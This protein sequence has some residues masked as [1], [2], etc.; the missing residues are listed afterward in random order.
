MIRVS[1]FILLLAA[2]GLPFGSALPQGYPVKPIRVIVPYGPGD[3]A[4]ILARLIG[5]KLTERF[6]QQLIVDNR[7]GAS[8]QLGLNLAAR[9][10]ADGYTIAVGQ[11]GNM[12]VAPHT[13]KKPL[14]D[15]L[16]DFV[17]VALLATNYAALV[18]HPSA[19]FK[20][21]K[22]L[23]AYAKTQ[24]GKLTFASGGE[25]SFPHLAFELL[26]VQASF[27]YLHVPYKGTA[28]IVADLIVDR[29]IQRWA[30]TRRWS[31]TY[32]LVGCACSASRIQNA[33]RYY[34]TCP[35]SP[36]PFQ[37]TIC[38]GGSAL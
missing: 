14:Y 26:R 21:V 15:P 8:G 6:G 36:K 19:P 34:P 23:I 5:Q 4:D 7:T 38:E 24:P 29:S 27:T 20:T 2:V 25:G 11:G 3:T 32:V 10:V 22:D 35:R 13:Y 12:V 37:T 18:V 17:P 31:R 1:P 33:P 9:A 28:A 30:P 16:N